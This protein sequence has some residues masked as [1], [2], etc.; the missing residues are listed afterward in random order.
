MKIKLTRDAGGNK[1][2]AT[3]ERVAK[4]AELLIAQDAAEPIKDDDK[5]EPKRRT[6]ASKAKTD[7]NKSGIDE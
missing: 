3:I 1:A 7:D 6:A 4:V 5:P 2:G